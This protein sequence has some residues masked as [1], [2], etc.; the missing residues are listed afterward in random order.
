MGTEQSVRIEKSADVWT[1]VLSRPEVKNAVDR[2]T[3][4]A[5]ADA[6]RTFDADGTAKVA[7]LWGEGGTFCAGADLKAFA[8]GARN[9]VDD[10]GDGPMGPTRLELSKPVIAA[11]S[12]FAVAGG[13]ELAVWCDLR[14]MEETAVVG[15]CCR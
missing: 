10:D 14:V 9:N 1:V 15:V 5:L 4:R 7:V 13:L 3:A 8:L 11:V 2:E 12:G 6:F